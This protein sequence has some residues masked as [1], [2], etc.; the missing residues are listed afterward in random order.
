ML[1]G[2]TA[3]YFIVTV[4]DISRDR[5]GEDTG[6]PPGRRRVPVVG[7]AH[8]ATAIL[9]GCRLDCDLRFGWQLEEEQFAF[10]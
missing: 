4:E 9:A 10:V 3:P 8:A 2:L 1:H 5:W 6:A 7:T